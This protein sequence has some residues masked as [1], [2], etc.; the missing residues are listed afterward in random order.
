MPQLIFDICCMKFCT[1]TSGMSGEGIAIALLYYIYFF[2]CS[3]ESGLFI[4]GSTW[5]SSGTRSCQNFQR[6]H[7]SVTLHN[8]RSYYGQGQPSKALYVRTVIAMLKRG[9]SLLRKPVSASSSN[10]RSSSKMGSPGPTPPPPPLPVPAPN[11]MDRSKS[12]FMSRVSTPGSG[13]APS[14]LL[15]LKTMPSPIASKQESGLMPPQPAP[16]VGILDLFGFECC[17]SQENGLGQLCANF[18]SEMMRNQFKAVVFDS[19]YDS[20]RFENVENPFE[21]RVHSNRP[22]LDL[23]VEEG[24]IFDVLDRESLFVKGHTDSLM[25]KLK[26]NLKSNT[27]FV[28]SNGDHQHL[29]GI[30]HFEK[31]VIYSP[32]DFIQDNRDVIYDDLLTIFHKQTCNFKFVTHL[33][34]QDLKN[35]PQQGTAPKGHYRRILSS[36]ISPKEETRKTLCQDFQSQLN[37]LVR[38]MSTSHNHFIRCIKSNANE[39]PECF[40][41]ASVAKQVRS[42]QILETAQLFVSG[43]PHGLPFRDFAVRY[44]CLLPQRAFA[45]PE[46]ALSDCHEILQQLQDESQLASSRHVNWAFGNHSVFFKES[47]RQQLEQY[48]LNCRHKAVTLIQSHV[49][50]RLAQSKYRIM[51]QVNLDR[52][53]ILVSERRGPLHNGEG[54]GPGVVGVPTPAIPSVP[55]SQ[56]E[57]DLVKRTCHIHGLDVDVPPP[58]PATRPYT[59]KGGVKLNFPHQRM[60]RQNYQSGTERNAVL[61]KGETVR[62]VGPSHRRG[63]LLVEQRGMAM[64][65]PSSVMDVA[66]PGSDLEGT[67]DL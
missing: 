3:S 7:N 4:A 23:L 27:N 62:V 30:K 43:L 48:R 41:F 61:M 59:V 51:R 11:P 5:W 10:S 55:P 12:P 37:F 6:S 53:R 2:Y 66:V 42:L 39:E 19:S 22:V 21:I 31:S 52:R 16:F 46:M 65:V 67:S 8:G 44:S 40:D 45:S 20:L 32:S 13:G 1:S 63:Y 17:H 38:L 36:A 14:P 50:R 64:N 54:T 56:Y 25:S 24:A 49:R 35:L 58:I 18:C 9:N 60:M 47:I 57:M 26:D 29:F 33:F 15:S 34:Q 28:C